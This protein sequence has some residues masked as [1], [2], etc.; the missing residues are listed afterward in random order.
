MLVPTRIKTFRSV[1]GNH[2]KYK[3]RENINTKQK[4]SNIMIPDK[5]IIIHGCPPREEKAKDPERRTYDKHWL[6]WTKEQLEKKGIPTFIPL[7]PEPWKPIYE[8]FKEEFEKIEVTENTILIGTSCGCAFLTRWLGDTKK[9]IYKLILTAPWKIHK[10]EGKEINKEFYDFE[11]DKTIPERVKEIIIFTSDT[12][13]PEV[14]ENLDIYVDALGGKLIDLKGY[15]HYI[16]KHM[17][18][19]EFPELIEEVLN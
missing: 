6:P 15:G 10:K 9:K 18:K 13:I 12:H 8:K 5:C 16:E 17:G 1:G 3:K 2:N 14:K 11:I 4:D 7:M 19:K